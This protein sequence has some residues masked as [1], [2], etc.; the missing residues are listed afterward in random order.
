MTQPHAAMQ[1][2]FCMRCGIGR[3]LARIIRVDHSSATALAVATPLVGLGLFLQ[4]DLDQGSAGLEA[5]TITALLCTWG[6]DEIS[7]RMFVGRLGRRSGGAVVC[8]RLKKPNRI[9]H[10]LECG[11]DDPKAILLMIY[12]Q[13]RWSA[14][15]A[16]AAGLAAVFAIADGLL[17]GIQ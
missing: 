8:I 4:I 14:W 6:R 9:R 17:P 16:I 2:K 12:K 7:V 10:G 15:A 11:L 13:S 3:W 1:T 5:I